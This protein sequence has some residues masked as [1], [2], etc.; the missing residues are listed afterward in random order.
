MTEEASTKTTSSKLFQLQQPDCNAAISE[1]AGANMLMT[2][3]HSEGL[4][5]H[6]GTLKTVIPPEQ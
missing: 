2:V 4:E 1:E 3:L 6:L 5:V